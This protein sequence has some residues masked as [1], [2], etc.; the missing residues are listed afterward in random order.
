MVNPRAVRAG[1]GPGPAGEEQEGRPGTNREK[2]HQGLSERYL[3]FRKAVLAGARS[4]QI[5]CR[6]HGMNK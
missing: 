2:A 6:R 5:E 3:F 4:G 1:S